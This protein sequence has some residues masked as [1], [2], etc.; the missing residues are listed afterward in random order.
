MKSGLQKQK[1]MRAHTSTR[2]HTGT[3][4]TDSDMLNHP[5]EV[6]KEEKRNKKPKRWHRTRKIQN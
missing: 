5:M 2:A 4:Y 3:C 1:D 6:R